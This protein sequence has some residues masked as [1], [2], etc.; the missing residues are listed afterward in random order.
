MRSSEAFRDQLRKIRRRRGW[1]QADLADRLGIEQW[2][3][4]RLES[5]ETRRVTLDEV[6]DVA[7]ALGVSPLHLILPPTPRAR[8]HVGGRTVEARKARSWIRGEQPLRA[9]DHMFFMSSMPPDEWRR[10][11]PK[12]VLFGGKRM[13]PKDEEEK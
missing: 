13:S 3:V 1:S 2:D 8:V 12:E 11:F 9:E 7:D 10:I 4:S 6:L 5:D